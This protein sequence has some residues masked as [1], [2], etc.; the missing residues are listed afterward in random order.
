M[1][2]TG[3]YHQVKM[4]AGLDSSL[5]Q[6]VLYLNKGTDDQMVIQLMIFKKSLKS[7]YNI[8]K[9]AFNLL[10]RCCLSHSLDKKK[11]I[12]YAEF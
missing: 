9:G 1:Y 3:E 11:L 5:R 8:L 4:K 7:L 12:F 6:D 2:Y 10:S